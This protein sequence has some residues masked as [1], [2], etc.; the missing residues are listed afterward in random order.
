MSHPKATPAPGCKNCKALFDALQEAWDI[1]LT[2]K[3][4]E[5]GPPS[6][7]APGDQFD[8]RPEPQRT[9]T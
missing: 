5:P 1:I 4:G 8:K 3:E 9:D 2:M 6:F 7:T